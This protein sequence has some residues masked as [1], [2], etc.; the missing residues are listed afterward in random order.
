M[1]QARDSSDKER[2]AET[3]PSSQAEDDTANLVDWEGPDDAA[4]PCNW[5]GRKRW[6]H[7]I[8]VAILG[9]IPYVL[10][11]K[12]TSLDVQLD[13]LPSPLIRATC[14]Q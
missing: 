11:C 9:L 14:M 6:A 5:P 1:S 4:N 2:A 8:T 12:F 3:A 10:V 13:A 7:I